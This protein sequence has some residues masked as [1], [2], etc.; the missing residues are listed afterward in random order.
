MSQAVQEARSVQDEDQNG[1][2]PQLKRL[3]LADPVVPEG[4]EVLESEPGLKVEDHTESTRDELRAALRGAAGLIV[5]SRTRVDA[6]LLE[7][8][9]ALEVIGRAGVGVDNIDLEAA[10]RR[11]IAVLN[12]P[13]GNTVSTA[14]L[15]FGLM[16]AA[17]RRIAE[18]DRTVREGLWERK[19]LRGAQLEGKTLG[20]IGAGRIGTEVIRRGRVFGMEIVVFDPYLTVE[21]AS[22]LGLDRVEL[23]ELL[24]RADVVTLH[25]PLNDSTRGMIGAVELARMKDDAILVNAARGGLVDEAALAEAL[26]SGRLGAAGLDVYAEEPPPSE[27]AL[28]D[29]PNLVMTPHLGASTD[30]AQ[31]EVSREIARAVRDAL[32]SADFGGALN[33]PN[34]SLADRGRMRPVLSLGTRLGRLLAALTDGCSQRVDV[35]YAGPLDSILRPLAAAAMEGFLC[36]TVDM[37]L[38]LVNALAIAGERGIDVGRVRIGEVADYTNYVELRA[39]NGAEETVVGGALLGEGHHPRIVQIGGF[40]VDTVPEGVLL[41]VRNRDVPGVIGEVGMRLGAAGINI[42]GYHLGRK[43]AEGRALGVI[44]VDDELPADFIAELRGLAAVDEVLQVTFDV[45]PGRQTG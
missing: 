11:G 38:N 6:E 36:S 23:E 45:C 30:E 39:R 16:L 28:R 43:A 27:S 32:V 42:G 4:L 37:P 10:T 12:A 9:D 33:A 35:G 5:R 41:L 2:G 26:R 29:A 19:R 40:H 7:A 44:T 8:A 14:E 18:G 34:V 24:E 1:G 13:G 15:A 25:V 3:V 21:R 17:A 22:D 31:R 20:V